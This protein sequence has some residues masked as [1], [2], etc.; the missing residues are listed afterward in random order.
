MPPKKK[1]FE[2]KLGALSDIVMRMEQG[3]LPLEEALKRYEEGTKLAKDLQKELDGAEK[4]LLQLKSGLV[5]SEEE[6]DV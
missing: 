3:G 4:T 6:K 5:L 1:T 2:D